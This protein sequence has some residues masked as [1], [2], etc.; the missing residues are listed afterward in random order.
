MNKAKL[1]SV[2]FNTPKFVAV[3]KI[4]KIPSYLEGFPEGNPIRVGDE[5]EYHSGDPSDTWITC[6]HDR[7]GRRIAIAASYLKFV[8]YRKVLW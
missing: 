2:L 4:K 7:C 1:K 3:F 8:E 5:V 6:I